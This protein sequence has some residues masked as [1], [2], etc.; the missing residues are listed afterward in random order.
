M[1]KGKSTSFQE[2]RRAGRP[3]HRVGLDLETVDSRE[4]VALGGGM[5]THMPFAPE[6]PKAPVLLFRNANSLV[7]AG[8]GIWALG[9]QTHM[10]LSVSCENSPKCVTQRRPTRGS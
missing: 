8:A 2:A 3:K 4:S 6:S 7:G 1:R 10:G 5:L 9:F